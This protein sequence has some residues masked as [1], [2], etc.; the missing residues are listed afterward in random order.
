MHACLAI[1]HILMDPF[2][3]STTALPPPP[4]P[5]PPIILVLAMY[6]RHH[7]HNNNNNLM[8]VSLEQDSKID[9]IR[10]SLAMNITMLSNTLAGQPSQAGTAILSGINAFEGC[11]TTIEGN[12]TIHPS[13][14][15][16]GI[17]VPCITTP[18]V[19]INQVL[20]LA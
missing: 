9:T 14:M 10:D 4:P 1:A 2:P 15:P 20:L 13:T 5:P 12:C 3:R 17:P 11:A 7:H 19:P 8:Q 6:A 18:E 16:G